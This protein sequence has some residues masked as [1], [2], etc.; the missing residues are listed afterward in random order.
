MG[1][2][3]WID[4]RP[5]ARRGI[6][7]P[8][9]KKLPDARV[10][11]R[12]DDL[13]AMGMPYQMAMA[14]AHGK[15]DLNEALERMAQKDRVQKL[16][17]DHE[18]SC[19]LATQVAMGHADLEQVLARRRLQQHRDTHRERTCLVEGAAITLGLTGGRTLTG[20]VRS[21]DA[22]SFV[23]QEDGADPVELHK[24]QAKF[25]YA[26]S[27]WKVVKKALRVDKR[28]AAQPREPA[29]RPQ[30]R[31]SCSDKRLFG[32]MERHLDVSATTLEGD[33]LRGR[34]AWF[35]RYEFALELKP[36]VEL[37]LFRHALR[38]ISAH[39]D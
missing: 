34:V 8:R 6:G 37:V 21:V 16:M 19:A 35:S 29:L 38:D 33:L 4:G 7:G 11:K 1:S 25:A 3:V 27:A 32:Y 14:V 13:H 10:K 24:L 9:R 28:V 23:F 18:L 20:V 17:R 36:G 30:D 22:Y 5:T 12:A 2:S 26:P 39:V 15:L 31:Y